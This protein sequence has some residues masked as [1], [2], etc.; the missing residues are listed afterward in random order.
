MSLHK[1]GTVQPQ[2]HIITSYCYTERVAVSH[3]MWENVPR[4]SPTLSR[5]SMCSICSLPVVYCS[6]LHSFVHSA[7]F[8]VF[9]TAAH[10]NMHCS[11]CIV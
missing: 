4:P 7:C 10:V 8:P 1:Y 6:T 5:A 3:V 9:V 11:T 2:F